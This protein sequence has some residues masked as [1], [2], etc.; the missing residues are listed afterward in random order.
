MKPLHP[1]DTLL[2]ALTNEDS[3]TRCF[4]EEGPSLT[5][6]PSGEYVSV[7]ESVVELLLRQCANPATLEEVNQTK[8]KNFNLFSI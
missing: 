6:N 5:S 8:G 2:P 3:S 1:L 7:I 4:N